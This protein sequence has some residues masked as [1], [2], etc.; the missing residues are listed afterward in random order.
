MVNNISKIISKNTYIKTVFYC[1]NCGTN[2]QV[3]MKKLK[4]PNVTIMDAARVFMTDFERPKD[5][6]DKA[7]A[8][9]ASL[10]I[11]AIQGG[12]KD[13]FNTNVIN[14]KPYE[15]S[16]HTARGKELSQGDTNNIYVTLQIQQATQHEAEAFAKTLKKYLEKDNKL[17]KIGSN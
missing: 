8:T 14:A 10:G 12:P 2:V 9:R 6:S 13:G 7:A 4:D 16:L 3:K 5:Q 15:M 1:L 17:E 11:G